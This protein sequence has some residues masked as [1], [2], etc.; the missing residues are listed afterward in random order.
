MPD[1]TQAPDAIIT[2]G[3]RM[4]A[5]GKYFKRMMDCKH[6]QILNPTDNPK[7]YDLIVSPE[8]D[9]LKANNVIISKGSL[10]SITTSSLIQY[11]KSYQDK[12]Q[13]D[14]TKVICLMLGNPANAFFRNLDDLVMQIKK[15]Y[16]SHQLHVCG[17]RRT[18]KKVRDKIRK[19][20]KQAQSCWLSEVDGQ[21]PYLFLLASSDVLLVT[22]DSINMVSE[23]CAKSR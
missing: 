20:F 4:A 17:S 3:R 18:N 21:N 22:A 9:R 5:V 10:H 1:K 8:H 6:I 19:S 7:K 12:F 14:D 23:A 15:K 13:L 11:Q 16:P 2:C